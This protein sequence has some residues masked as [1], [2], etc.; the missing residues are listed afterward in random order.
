VVVDLDV[1]DLLDRLEVEDLGI[2]Q[3]QA[4][5]VRND[6]PATESLVL[7]GFAVDR[8]ANVDLAALQLLRGRCQRRLDSLENDFEVD[9]LFSR[10]IA[11]TSINSSRFIGFDLRLLLRR[12]ESRS[13]PRP[14]GRRSAP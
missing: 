14:A 11:S 9:A 5:I 13:S 4:G 7:A 10:E 6:M 3:L 12:G 8:D 2:G 1:R